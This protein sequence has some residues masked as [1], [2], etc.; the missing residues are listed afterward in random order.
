MH[1]PHRTANAPCAAVAVTFGQRADHGTGYLAPISA[2]LRVLAFGVVGVATNRTGF[3]SKPAPENACQ[4]Y[5]NEVFENVIL[6][7][8][9][10]LWPV[11]EAIFT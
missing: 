7:L 6:I 4:S 8:A 2:P 9:F 1:R 5:S 10:K 3:T 11:G